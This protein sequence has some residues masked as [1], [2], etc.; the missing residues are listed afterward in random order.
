[1]TGNQIQTVFKDLGKLIKLAE[2]GDTFAQSLK[3]HLM[4]TNDQLTDATLDSY[5]LYRLVVMPTQT[6]M[7]RVVSLA[8][9]I[10]ARAKLAVE[11]YLIVLAPQ[12]PVSP[13]ASAAVKLT[14][15]KNAMTANTQSVEP[16]GIIYSFINDHWGV[17]LPT[18]ATPTCL[19]S[20]CS[21]SLV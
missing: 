3:V 8:D 11:N 7:N 18:N 13:S 4:A 19:D 21:S 17:Q 1:M 20:W 12:V 14:A 2:I 6:S 15:L 10:L 16:S 9:A 5:E